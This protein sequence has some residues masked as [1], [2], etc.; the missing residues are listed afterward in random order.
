MPMFGF[1][2]YKNRAETVLLEEAEG[3]INLIACFSMN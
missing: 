3:V 1:T 2:E